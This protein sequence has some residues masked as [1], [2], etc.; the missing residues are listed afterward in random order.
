[1]RPV[2]LTTERLLLRPFTP[3]DT[4]AVLDAC[5]DP[6][7]LHYVPVPNPYRREDAELFTGTTAPEGWAKDTGYSLGAFRRDDG[8][9]V[10]SYGLDHKEQGMYELGYWA[11]KEQ[12]GNGY[13]AEAAGAL[14][15]WGFANLEVHRIEW[16][17]MVGNSGSRAVAEKLGFTVEGTLRRRSITNGAPHDWWIGGLLREDPHTHL[18]PAE[19]GTETATAP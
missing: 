1:M 17:A 10:G 7:I 4:D 5:Q 9:F 15:A 2:T 12:R 18:H 14:C 13:S 8:A 6:D 16:W 3:A 19:T 11:A